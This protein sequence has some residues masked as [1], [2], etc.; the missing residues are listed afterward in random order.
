GEILAAASLF[1][2]SRP[3]V[4]LPAGLELPYLAAL[5][6]G[7]GALWAIAL[8]RLMP[9]PLPGLM[10]S[11]LAVAAAGGVLLRFTLPDTGLVRRFEGHTRPVRAF[12]LPPD[13]SKL[14]SGGD[15]DAV[16]VWD[17]ET[18]DLLKRLRGLHKPVLG[19]LVLS[20]EKEIVAGSSDGTLRRW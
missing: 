7:F 10:T 15:D 3:G 16:R 6:A 8:S 5:G 19:V 13:G 9:L 20:E 14:I 4:E 12:A 11:A 17:I 18:G 2:G 1:L